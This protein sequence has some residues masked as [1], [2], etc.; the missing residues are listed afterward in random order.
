MRLRQAPGPEQKSEQFAVL[1]YVKV[2]GSCTWPMPYLLR[3]FANM[4]ELMSRPDWPIVTIITALVR[5][6]MHHANTE[7]GV[8]RRCSQRQHIWLFGLFAGRLQFD[9]GMT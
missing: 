8:I 5:L 3:I 6:R 4:E 7:I 9:Q 2:T 1:F